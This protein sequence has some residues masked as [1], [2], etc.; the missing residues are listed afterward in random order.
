[1]VEPSR[2]GIRSA[3]QAVWFT[4]VDATQDVELL[5]I[6]IVV[7]MQES[8]AKVNKDVRVVLQP[9]KYH[10]APVVSDMHLEVEGAAR[11]IPQEDAIQ[12]I[13]QLMAA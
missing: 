3:V 12:E 13:V 1:V 11:A 2:R 5:I 7:L 6:V 9:K 10:F 8:K 4:K